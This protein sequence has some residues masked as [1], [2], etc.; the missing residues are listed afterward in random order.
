MLHRVI[1]QRSRWA[2][3]TAQGTRRGSLW[4][5]QDG[6]SNDRGESPPKNQIPIPPSQ[7]PLGSL[8]GT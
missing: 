2:A 6:C 7:E 1:E 3:A 8:P 5:S 4:M